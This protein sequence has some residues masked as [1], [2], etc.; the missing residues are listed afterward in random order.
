MFEINC[1]Y[2]PTDDISLVKNFVT[3]FILN[4]LIYFSS[5]CN[6]RERFVSV[7]KNSS[8]VGTQTGILKNILLWGDSQHTVDG[9]VLHYNVMNSNY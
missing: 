6:H 5:S 4:N 8:L 1:N 7:I 2:Q 3:G 9:S